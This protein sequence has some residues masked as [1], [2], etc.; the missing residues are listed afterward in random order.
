MYVLDRAAACLAFVV[1]GMAIRVIWRKRDQLQGFL[2]PLNENPFTNMIVTEI[3]ITTD[4]CPSMEDVHTNLS[5]PGVGHFWGT[6]R[7]DIN[8]T[9]PERQLPAALRI[10]SITRQ[11]AAREANAQA[12]LYARVALLFFFALLVTWI[13]TSVNRLYGLVQ[14]NEVN[15]PLNYAASFVFPLQGFW[16]AI[17]YIITSQTAVRGLFARIFFRSDRKTQ[18]LHSSYDIHHGPYSRELNH[19]SKNGSIKSQQYLV[20]ST[21]CKS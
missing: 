19:V 4:E 16:N 7:V 11:I 6:V 5:I 15:F 17:I 9:Q 18:R 12:F 3:D 2:N 20:S 1:Y 14:P 13:P 10:R 8:A 21:L